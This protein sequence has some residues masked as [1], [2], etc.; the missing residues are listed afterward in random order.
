MGVLDT[1]VVGVLRDVEELS[2]LVGS[3]GSE[4]SGDGSVGEAGNFL[5]ALLNN[6]K[7]DGAELAADDASSDSLSQCDS[8][9][10]AEVSAGSFSEQ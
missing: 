8:F 4:S 6:D 3:L 7:V 5:F 9:S 2:D 1:D 10:S